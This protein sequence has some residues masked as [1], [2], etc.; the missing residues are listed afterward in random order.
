MNQNFRWYRLRLG[1]G[2][3]DATKFRDS[4]RAYSERSN[5]F[6]PTED[7]GWRFLRVVPL[8]IDRI[9]VSG[10]SVSERIDS[11]V[12]TNIHLIKLGHASYL[13]I[14]NPGRSVRPLMT[15]LELAFGF[16][17]STEIV[18]FKDLKVKAIVRKFDVVKL[19]AYRVTNVAFGADCVGRLEL[20]SRGGIELAKVDLLRGRKYKPD[21]A[22]YEV[23][24]RGVVGNFSYTSSGTLRVGGKLA[25]LILERFEEEIPEL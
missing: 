12:A 10:R 19:V 17:F 15:A 5:W 4:L 18:D 24:Y 14:V 21:F 22:K 8:N 6:A 25:D 3:I 1:G 13:R 16:G 11:I 20:A 23:I 7:G 2:P 9:D